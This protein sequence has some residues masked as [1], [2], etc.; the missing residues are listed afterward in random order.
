[1]LNMRLGALSLS[2]G[3]VIMQDGDIVALGVLR[4]LQR[5][6]MFLLSINLS[7]QVIC[8]NLRGV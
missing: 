4:R 5:L 8:M 3:D 2:L 7:G 1:M 6:N